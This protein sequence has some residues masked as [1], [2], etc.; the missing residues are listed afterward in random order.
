[1][2]IPHIF[3]ILILSVTTACNSNRSEDHG[4]DH[5]PNG[6]S[7]GP[8]RVR[9]DQTI[10]TDKTE[11]FVE[12]PVLVVGKNS[13]FAAHFTIL[14]GHKPI[15]TG[16]VKVTLQNAQHQISAVAEKP[17]SSGIFK[18]TI[19]PDKA[20]IYT[21][22]FDVNTPTFKD[23]IVI[24]NIEVYTSTKEANKANKE[25]DSNGITFLKEQAWK[26]D[27]QTH[28]VKEKDIFNVIKTSG[29]WKVAPT[30]QINIAAT[31]EGIVQFKNKTL[32]LGTSV[33]KGQVILTINGQNLTTYNVKAEIKKAETNYKTAEQIYNRKKKLFSKQIIPKSEFETAEEHYLI[34]KTN[35]ETL[36]NGYS[37]SGKQIKAPFSGVIKHININNGG[38]VKEGDAL[39]TLVK[40]E[41]NILETYVGLSNAQALNSINNIWFQPQ[42]D[43]WSSLA[44]GNGKVL[45]VSQS[46]DQLNPMLSVSAQ[47]NQWVAYP[48]GAYTEV[49]IAT[50]TPTKGLIIPADALLEDYGVYSVIVQRSG[51]LFERRNVSVGKRNGKNIEIVKGLSA[52][53]VVVTI[54]AYQVKMAS[55]SGKAPAHGHAH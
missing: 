12:Y 46:V 47:V 21:L 11:L 36:K 34:S 27:F 2:K 22:I 18:P 24:N 43:K 42:K 10:W 9:T 37:T 4:H 51:E 20:G 53:E 1:M 49:H 50:G 6:H 28:P 25:E 44:E 32:M 19:K 29:V 45:S 31:S 40:T 55:M 5:G 30:D 16:M 8:S 23:Q 33:K 3:F 48:D 54:G 17:S 39:F 41:A 26:M 14:N 52:G 38:F 7:H 15:E 13:R 35:Y